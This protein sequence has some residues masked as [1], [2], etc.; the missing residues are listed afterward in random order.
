MLAC[1]FQ[2]GAK[3]WSTDDGGATWTSNDLEDSL[4]KSLTGMQMLTDT[5]GYAYGGPDYLLQTDDA[6]VTWTGSGTAR[7]PGTPNFI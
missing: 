1:M 2:M 5:F 3:T 4:F 6:G 7:M